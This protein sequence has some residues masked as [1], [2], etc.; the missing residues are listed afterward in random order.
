[1]RHRTN[2][3]SGNRCLPASHRTS[4]RR[5][6]Y[7]YSYAYG[8][9]GV[10]G[11]FSNRYAAGCAIFASVGGLSFGYDQGVIANVLVMKDL[12]Q[13]AVLELGALFGA[14][15][16]GVSADKFSRR[17]SIFLASR[18]VRFQAGA[19]SLNHLILGRAIGGV[20][21]YPLYIAEISSPE[22]RG[23]LMALEQLAIVLGVVFGFWFGF[24]TRNVQGCFLLPPSPRFLVLKGRLDDAMQ[25]LS[26]LRLRTAAEAPYDPLLQLEF[27]EMQ[28]DVA[29][30]TQCLGT[31]DREGFYFDRTLLGIM[32]MFFQQWSGINALLYY[33]PTLV[34]SIGFE[35]DLVT[36]LVSGGIGIVQFL[37]VIPAILY[38]DSAGRKPLLRG[39]SALMTLSHIVIA[40]L[41]Y[42]YEGNWPAHS[43]AAWVAIMYAYGVSFGPIGWVLP[44][45]V[46]PLSMRS[47]GVSL[48]TASNWVNN[49]LIGLITPPM[50]QSSAATT[51][52]LFGTACFAAHF[53]ST[54]LVPET[55]GISLEEMD[56]VFGTT[57]GKDDGRVKV[58]LQDHRAISVARC[59][60]NDYD[61]GVSTMAKAE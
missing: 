29:L 60:S 23:S 1:M 40:I 28:V 2:S 14:L 35:G 12:F 42:H 55:A 50:I 51:F 56:A 57:A 15:L 5:Y 24:L 32:I 22:L 54:Y 4:A 9:T 45:E 11:L 21:C 37:A 26:R 61:F 47:K 8:P 58:E 13:A 19:Q 31:N 46:F 10:S 39:G 20:V 52:L 30:E 7:T 43:S 25:S 36:L 53:W 48:A 41:I 18:R 38:L 16:A 59:L 34:R 6:T 27:L 44:S 49:F 17:R 33:G 3:L